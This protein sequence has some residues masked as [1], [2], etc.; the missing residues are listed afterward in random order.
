MGAELSN[1]SLICL[2]RIHSS[3]ALAAPTRVPA[4]LSL[5]MYLELSRLL[6][7]VF[8]GWLTKSQEPVAND[9][10]LGA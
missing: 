2:K 4:W 3:K 1:R 9:V 5:I 6:Q 10:G 8:P 7:K